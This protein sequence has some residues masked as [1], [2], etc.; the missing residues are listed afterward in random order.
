M[1]LL[2]SLDVR[3]VA[4]DDDFVKHAHNFDVDRR[5]TRGNLTVRGQTIM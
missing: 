3:G 2:I 4:L 1:L 5:L